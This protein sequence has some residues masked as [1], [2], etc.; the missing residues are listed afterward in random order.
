LDGE[1][2]VLRA[3]CAIDAGEITISYGDESDLWFAA[4]GDADGESRNGGTR[5]RIRTNANGR[6]ER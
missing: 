5:R 6:R 4:R 2:L 1:S 3:R